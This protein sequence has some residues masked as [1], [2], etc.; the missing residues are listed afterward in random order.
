MSAPA[1]LAVRLTAVSGDGKP[2]IVAV[3]LPGKQPQ[4]SV[5]ANGRASE[6]IPGL[7]AGE[8]AV[9]IDGKPRAMLLIGGEPGP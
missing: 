3:R 1:F 2:H 9:E 6:L 4:I 5:P 7:K 8:Y